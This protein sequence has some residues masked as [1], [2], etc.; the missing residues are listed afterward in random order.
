MHRIRR[1][2]IEVAIW[3]TVFPA[4]LSGPCA[5]AQDPGWRLRVDVALVDPAGDS[6]AVRVDGVSVAVDVDTGAGIG[7][8]GEYQFSRRLGFEVGFL[9]SGSVSVE[10]SA[11]IGDVGVALEV[12]SFVPLTAGLNVHLTPK[13]RPDLYVGPLLAYAVYS[14]VGVRTRPGGATTYE[15][16]NN[17][18]GYGAILGLDLPIGRKGW[19]FNFNLRYIKTKMNGGSGG[20]RVDVDY[21][22]TILGIGFGYRF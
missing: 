13:A 8:R 10:A 21:D 1:A 5:H 14:D 4:L 9:A 12:S 15:S 22:P 19:V 3:T 17:D 16:V 18:L 6:G 2:F 11:R 20:D 7:A